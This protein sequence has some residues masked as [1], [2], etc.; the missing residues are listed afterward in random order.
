MSLITIIIYLMLIGLLLWI[1]TTFVP[2]EPVI[3][4][5]MIAVVL[6]VIVLW[7]LQMVGGPLANVRI[8]SSP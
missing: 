7:L 1:I 6:V 5:V 3:R 8:G 4:N 2:M